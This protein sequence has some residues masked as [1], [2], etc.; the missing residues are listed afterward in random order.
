MLKIIKGSNTDDLEFLINKMAADYKDVIDQ[1]EVGA[2]NYTEITDHDYTFG[3]FTMNV[4][5]KLKP[6]AS[7]ARIDELT[8]DQIKKHDI[9]ALLTAVESEKKDEE[10]D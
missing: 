1:L 10:N 2:P 3:M 8:H 7:Q 5:I 9:N 4:K 6:N